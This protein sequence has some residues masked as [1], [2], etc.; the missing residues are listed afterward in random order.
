H[1]V[2]AVAQVLPNAGDTGNDGLAAELAVGAHFSG[3]TRH[4]RGKGAELL[5]HGVDG[6]FQ[7]KDFAAHIDG[8]LLG[9]VAVGHGNGNV[10]DVAHL[11]RQIAGHRVHVVRQVFPGA[12]DAG[13]NC[14]TAELAV[15][16][17]FASDTSDF[18]REGVELIHHCVDGVLEFENFALHIYGD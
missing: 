18:S 4:F 16:A 14:L 7:L 15:G 6:F 8:N 10:G 2:D 13:H 12:A 17:D 9:E 1:G 5:H 3:Y 11:G